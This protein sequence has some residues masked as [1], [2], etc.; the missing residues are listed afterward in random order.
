MT[1][2]PIKTCE[3]GE[4]LHDAAVAQSLVANFGNPCSP[5]GVL[6]TKKQQ[7]GD[8]KMANTSYFEISLV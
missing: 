3:C 6:T 2:T 1:I 8:T 5:I 7:N 4:K